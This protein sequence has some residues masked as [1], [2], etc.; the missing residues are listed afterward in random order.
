MPSEKRG[1]VV[2]DFSTYGTRVEKG[3]EVKLD[4]EGK[5]KRGAM[6]RIVV[7][8]VILSPS[9]VPSHADHDNSSN[10][11]MTKSKPISALS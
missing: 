5:T 4:V 2:T 1:T 3:I 7:G 6:L 9:F 8:K 10:K 11:K